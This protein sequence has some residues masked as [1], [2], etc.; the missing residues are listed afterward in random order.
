M[1]EVGILAT[2]TRLKK[3]RNSASS[4]YWRSV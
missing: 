1:W 3:F 2:P 4:F